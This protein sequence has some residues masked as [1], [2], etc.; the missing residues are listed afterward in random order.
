MGFCIIVNVS[1]FFLDILAK[2]SKVDTDSLL[3]KSDKLSKPGRK[4][5][6]SEE[7]KTE[8]RKHLA[9]YFDLMKTPGKAACEDCI[10]NSNGKLHSRNWTDIKYFVYNAN[11][12]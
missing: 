12:K 8:I 7:E 11:K 10:K 1:V 2:R 5:H 9:K 6:W 4:R 3:V